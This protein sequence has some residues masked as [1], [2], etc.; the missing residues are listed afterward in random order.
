MRTFNELT[1]QKPVEGFFADE[2][3]GKG[4]GGSAGTASCRLATEDD[5]SDFLHKIMVNI[6]LSRWIIYNMCIKYFDQ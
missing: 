1:S 4:I 3:E 6:Q 5:A 2:E